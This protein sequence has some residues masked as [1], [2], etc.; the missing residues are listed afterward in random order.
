M[1]MKNSLTF[2]YTLHQMAYWATA[3]GT[4]VFCMTVDK[5]DMD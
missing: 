1:L 3:A 5:K 2:C 4:L